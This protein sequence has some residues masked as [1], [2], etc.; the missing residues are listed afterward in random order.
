MEP[1]G[2]KQK[3]I[4]AENFSL[5]R[6][7]VQCLTCKEVFQLTLQAS[8]TTLGSSLATQRWSLASALLCRELVTLRCLL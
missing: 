8:Q 3:S 6:K 2:N 4:T 1:T 5:L 7:R